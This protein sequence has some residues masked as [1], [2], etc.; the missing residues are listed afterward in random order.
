[1]ISN[2]LC[3]FSQESRKL[4]KRVEQLNT[5]HPG[6]TPRLAV[7]QVGE[8]QHTSDFMDMANEI[9]IEVTQVKFPSSIH[10]S[11]VSMK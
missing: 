10:Q 5:S 1:M 9:G 7:V 3:P 6:F 8:N 4:A 2:I 11:M